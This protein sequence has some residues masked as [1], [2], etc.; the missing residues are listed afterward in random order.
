MFE[1][2][3]RVRL[4]GPTART[5]SRARVKWLFGLLVLASLLGVRP[6]L[7]DEADD[8]YLQVYGL[9]QQADELSAGGKRAPAKAKYLEAYNG[10]SNLKKNYPE[11]NTKLVALRIKYVTEKITALSEPPPVAVTNE[12]GTN[13][14]EVKRETKAA[15]PASSGPLKLLG[16]GAE[17]RKSLRLHP[18]PGDKQTLHLSGKVALETKMGGDQ[19]PPMKLP[20]ITTAMDMTEDITVKEVS[21]KGDIT[22]ELTLGDVSFGSEPAAGAAQ[23]ARAKKSAL[24]ALKG[25]SATCTVSS[26]GLSKSVEFTAP[27]GTDPQARLF[28]DQ[29]KDVA[30]QVAVPLPEE[31]VGVG[32][33]WE[34]KTPI[35]TRGISLDQTASYELVAV[36]GEHL[37]IKSTTTQRGANQKMDNPIMPNMKV[38]LTK[39]AGKGTSE[40]QVDTGKLMPSSGTT[41][42]HSEI[43]M[44][45]N[46]GGQNQSFIMKTDM[47]LRLE[48]K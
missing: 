19:P 35:K 44:S 5:R 23:P 17:P 28:M 42:S 20:A 34:V 24:P 16:A 2:S 21:A 38:D 33:K 47:E 29:M 40:L 18:T 32:A 30:S 43:G 6:V 15:T 36:E 26:Q 37:K 14:P 27:P 1:F 39:W 9:I 8:Q 12:S 7:A 4:T 13:T 31:P 22:Y 25:L 48:A 11:W 45:L 41:E 3:N 10:L 46:L